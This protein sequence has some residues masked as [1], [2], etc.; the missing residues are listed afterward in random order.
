MRHRIEHSALASFFAPNQSI[1]P[2]GP[3][4]AMAEPRGQGLLFR[5][6]KDGEFVRAWVHPS[7]MHTR[8][9]QRKELVSFMGEEQTVLYV[10]IYPSTISHRWY[11]ARGAKTGEYIEVETWQ[12]HVIPCAFW[13]SASQRLHVVS[14]QRHHGDAGNASSSSGLCDTPP[15]PMIRTWVGPRGI[16][17]L[18]PKAGN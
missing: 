13:D 8:T 5:G 6:T 16:S 12:V 1:S 17:A 7:A 18:D 3:G 10:S 2:L 14:L 15:G 11:R 4:A 9:L